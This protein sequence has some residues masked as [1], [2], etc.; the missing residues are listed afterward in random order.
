MEAAV[1]ELNG[2]RDTVER[3]GIGSLIVI[4]LFILLLKSGKFTGPLLTLVVNDFRALI[5]DLRTGHG[6]IK[7]GVTTMASCMK[8]SVQGTARLRAVVSPAARLLGMAASGKADPKEADRLVE[9]IH[10][11]VK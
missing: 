1:S 4:C 11:A 6:E 10:E 9:E 2:W 5:A 8:E 3:L 7:D